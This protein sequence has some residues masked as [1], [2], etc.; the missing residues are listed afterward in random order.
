MTDSA[1]LAQT[2][3][4]ALLRQQIDIAA[5]QKD[6]EKAR[7]LPSF[8][9]GYFNQSLIG[10]Y[11]VGQKE[12]YYGGGRRFQG[13]TA[14]VAIPIFRKPQQARVEAA[15]LGQQVGEATLSLTQ[16]NLQGELSATI[17]EIRKLQSSLTYYEQTGLPTARLLADKAGVAFRAGEIG[18]LQYSQAITQAYQTRA[19]YVDVLGA[20]NQTVI[21]LE[22]LLG[23]P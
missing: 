17:Q 18:Y 22:Q 14:G 7:L 13:L 23:L 10:T 19:S 4:L 11:L 3:E 12:V 20:Y 2:P 9:V 1:T 6:V 15:R 21:R 5:R 8:S 16:R